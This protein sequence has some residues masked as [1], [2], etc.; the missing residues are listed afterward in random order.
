[1]VWLLSS[2]SDRRAL[3]V[4]DGT[5][6]CAGYGPHYS[7]R[8]PGSKTFTGV[9][10]EIVLVSECGRA[11]WAC[12]RQKT[13]HA[14]GSGTSRGR[15]G[16]TDQ[17]ARYLW[18]NMMFRNLGAG[19]SSELIREATA[20]TYREWTKRY[21]TLPEE[22]L[23]TEVDVTKITS[24]N[25]GY[26]YMIAGWEKGVTKNK[27]LFLWAPVDRIVALEPVRSYAGLPLFA[28]PSLTSPFE[29]DK[30]KTLGFEL[31]PRR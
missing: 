7:R 10:Q 29:P 17:K 2:S 4:V 20:T 15:A 14:V 5:G 31:R 16:R 27:K 8:T 21:G 30:A 22:R 9:G 24:R 12:I 1:M 23:R 28:F 6:V 11:V 3:D 25:P 13:P 18:R 26:C 19:L